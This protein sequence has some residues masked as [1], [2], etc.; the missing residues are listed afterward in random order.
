MMREGE[1]ER[2]STRERERVTKYTKY[3]AA[4]FFGGCIKIDN[5]L[6]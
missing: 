4:F 1:R 5:L 3:S 6:R 2:V